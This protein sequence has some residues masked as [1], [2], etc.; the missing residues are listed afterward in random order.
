MSL[1][2]RLASV[3]TRVADEF[4]TVRD[5]QV[6]HIYWDDV[7]DVWPTPTTKYA[8]RHWHSEHDVTASAPTG[9][10]GKDIWFKRSA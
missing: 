2:T 9:M 8:V 10:S 5:E 7:L 1:A 4:N 3:V 6:E